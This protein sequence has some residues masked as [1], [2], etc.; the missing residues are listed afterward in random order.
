MRHETVPRRRLFGGLAS[1]GGRYRRGEAMVRSRDMIGAR[2]VVS[3]KVATCGAPHEVRPDRARGWTT[4][5]RI[6]SI[7]TAFV[8]RSVAWRPRLHVGGIER[9]YGALSSL[10]T[11]EPDRHHRRGQRCER[12]DA[13]AAARCPR[14]TPTFDVRRGDSLGRYVILQRLGAGGMGV[15]YAAYDPELDR[16]VAIKLWLADVTT[17]V[18]LYDGTG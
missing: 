2:D 4:A 10:S 12:S 8:A 5:T 3:A 6:G 16:T 14:G 13:R 9:R 17:G 1:A 18:S 7:M 15:V 11:C